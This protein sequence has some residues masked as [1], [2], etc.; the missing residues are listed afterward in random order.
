VEEAI[1]VRFNDTKPNV[2]ISELDE[3]FVDKTRRRYWTTNKTTIR[4]IQVPSS[5][6]TTSRI[7]RTNWTKSKKE[8]P[9]ELNHWRSINQNLDKRISQKRRLHNSHIKSGTQAH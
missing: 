4:T 8:P 1:H 6:R 2:E 9:R 3:S 7:K 5:N